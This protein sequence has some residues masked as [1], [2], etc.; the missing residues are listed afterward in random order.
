M[1][2]TKIKKWFKSKFK[3]KTVKAVKDF[4]EVNKEKAT[5]K[6]NENREQEERY[7]REETKKHQQRIKEIGET[8]ERISNFKTLP[9]VVYGKQLRNLYL[10]TQNGKTTELDT[11]IISIS[12]IY[13]IETKNYSGKIYGSEKQKNWVAWYSEKDKYPFYNPIRQ[14]EAHIK[15]LKSI[16]TETKE[17]CFFSIIVF[18]DKCELKKIQYDNTKSLIINQG[19]LLTEFKEILKKSEG[20]LS[21]QEVN[22]FFEKAKKFT[23]V[24]EETKQKHIENV[25]RN[26][27]NSYYYE[28]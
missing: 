5:I 1:L 20:K 3:R 11:L 15:A 17:N 2:F 28:N 21:R 24:C 19:I 14:N 25:K 22:D 7:T 4:A 6:K 23:N 18:S 27:A 12:G 9:I 26:K 13:A 8:G 16:F 10:P